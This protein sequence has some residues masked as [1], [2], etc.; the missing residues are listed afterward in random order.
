MYLVRLK[1]KEKG[2]VLGKATRFAKITDEACLDVTE[3]RRNFAVF[4]LNSHFHLNP[5]E[6]LYSSDDELRKSWLGPVLSPL[7]TSAQSEDSTGC[8]QI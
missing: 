3:Y 4:A 5:G 1:G 8:E 6:L 2:S 7:E